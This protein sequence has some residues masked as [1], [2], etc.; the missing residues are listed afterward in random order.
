MPYAAKT[1]IKLYRLLCGHEMVPKETN[2][3][4]SGSENLDTDH[5]RGHLRSHISNCATALTMARK[6]IA[7]DQIV[8]LIVGAGQASPSPPVGPAL[9]SKGVK[10]MDFCKV[11]RIASNTLTALLTKTGIQRPHIPLQSRHTHSRPNHR[12][13]RPIL[14]LLA[15]HTSH[16]DIAA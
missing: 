15:S 3:Q 12:P 5:L 6:A 11:R 14:P 16:S 8:K 7:K 9:G 10:S 4:D 13:P 1:A 2:S